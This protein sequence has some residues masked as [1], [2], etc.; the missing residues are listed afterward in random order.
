MSEANR[1]FQTK[2]KIFQLKQMYVSSKLFSRTTYRS[3]I[4][5]T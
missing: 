2:L 3:N 4:T 1:I 5:A